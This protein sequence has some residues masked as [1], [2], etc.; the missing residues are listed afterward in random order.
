MISHIP[1]YIRDIRNYLHK[2]PDKKLPRHVA[3]I[4][5]GNG[6]W[7][8]KIGKD[9]LY[10]HRE[11]MNSIRSVVSAAAKLNIPYL[12]LYA[13]STENWRRPQSEI[14]ALFNLLKYFCKKELTKFVEKNIR[15][16]FIGRTQKLPANVQY[17]MRK[18]LNATK[19]ST[20]MTLVIALNYGGQQEI[21][22]AVKKALKNP[23]LVKDPDKI[24]ETTFTDLFY[25]PDLP[26]V[27]FM[28][29]TS[30]EYRI[31]NFL[32]Y[33]IAYAE[34]FFSPLL[35]PEFKEKEFLVAIKE[36]LKRSRRFGGLGSVSGKGQNL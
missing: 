35:W 28:I 4:M 5:D 13:F 7:A 10:G 32:T 19:N 30:G 23:E 24:D 11:G 29:R 1:S 17:Y 18:T 31:S 14:T 15:V 27:D 2:N 34:L 6:R 12:T 36:Y 22:D 16:I 26:P 21:I 3:V 9:R 20:G 25:A 33:Q 8:K